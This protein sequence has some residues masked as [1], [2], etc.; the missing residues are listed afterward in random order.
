MVFPEVV[1]EWRVPLFG[2]ASSEVPG[3]WV[4]ALA[5]IARD[6]RCRRQGRAVS[7]DGVE[8]ALTVFSNRS[9]SIGFTSLTDEVD[10]G[11]FSVGRGFA[12]DTTSEQAMVWVAS[13]VQDELAGHEFVQW[14]SHNQGLLAPDIRS[15]AAVWVDGADRVVAPIGALCDDSL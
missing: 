9:V 8:W 15:G 13:V 11:S 5:A 4:A 14:P 10:L 1:H 2:E 6:L 3:G 7:F 12:F